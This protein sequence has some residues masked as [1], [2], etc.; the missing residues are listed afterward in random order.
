MSRCDQLAIFSFFNFS[1]EKHFF[2]IC[3]FLFMYLICFCAA[4]GFAI[5]SRGQRCACGVGQNLWVLP[6]NNKTVSLHN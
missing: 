3:P 6:I 2:F 4:G 1:N 5:F